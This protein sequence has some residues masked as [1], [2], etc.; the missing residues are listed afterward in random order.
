MA[1][2]SPPNKQRLL[3]AEHLDLCYG[4]SEANVAAALS[5]LGQGSHFVT[6]L[7]DNPLGHAAVNS[8]RRYG[9]NTDRVIFGGK[10]IGTYFVEHGATPR[11]GN[12]VY[13]RADS[14]FAN[15]TENDLNWPQL[16]ANKD[17]LHLTGI[18]PALSARCAQENLRALKTAKEIGL[19]TSFDPNYR[20]KLWDEK[21]AQQEMHH[22][23]GLVDVLIANLGVAKQMF[24]IQPSQV[25]L[26]P[27]EASQ[28]VA[29]QLLAKGD[30]KK[31]AMTLRSAISAN[32]D[33]VFAVF[34]DGEK[35]LQ[36]ETYR[37]QLVDRLGG[38]DAFTAGLIH[39]L[40][41]HWESQKIIDFA[42]AA[43]AYKQSIPG[44]I[45]LASEAEI[46]TAL[47]TDQV[48]KVLR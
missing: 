47:A 36:S 43:S 4:G 3:D 23:S 33:S 26:S 22:Y 5:Q 18:T 16:L 10:R 19:T 34:Y 46:I 39:G 21:T 37:L 45:L 31:I 44:D 30:F 38:G 20:A 32:E 11:P 41:E 28:D 13:D 29:M 2:L 48:G 35:F 9:V 17:W 25:N 1:R 42:C 24:A 7:P 27:I 12:V 15:L 14:A 40:S 6:R 8:L